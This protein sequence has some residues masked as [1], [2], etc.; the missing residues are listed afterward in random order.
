M[1]KLIFRRI[2]EAIP[3]LFVLITV[4]FFMMRLA[5][6]S[7]F[8]GERN[9]PPAVLANIEAKYHLNDPIWLQYFNYLKQLAQ[10]DFG[11][12]FK[13]KDFTVNELL[14][15]ALPVSV[16]IGLY[17]FILAVIL[18]VALGVLAA[19]K[20]NSW[21]DYTLMTLAMT[22]VVI[23][24]FVKAPLMVLIFAIILK[25]LPAGG[26]NDGA[27]MNLILPVTALALAYVASISRIMRGAMIEVMNS[28]FIR[29][30]RAKGLSTRYIV[31]KHALRP[32]ML[33]VISYL[34]PAFVG[35]ITGS[36][37]IE[38]IFVLP[39][40]GQLFVNGALNRDYGMVLSL[41]ILVG[42]LTIV[43]NAI[44]DILY[45]VIDP[46]IRY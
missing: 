13:Y 11:P 26:W 20:Q 2:L 34:G 25:W 27:L 3:T 19:L 43:F 7:P 37:V 28:P 30:A 39:G 46:K 44:V 4:S 42:V 8:T 18:G 10:G 36:I 35:I 12:S 16:E 6:G 33:P 40:I 45:A 1:I 23:P 14:E 22:G 15:K 9:L 17:A 24:S 41:T 21:L 29:T 32:A 31:C 5:P 38:T